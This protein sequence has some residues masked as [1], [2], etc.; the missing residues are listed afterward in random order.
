[1]HGY[2]PGTLLLYLI[3]PN[4]WEIFGWQVYDWAS[5]PYH[6]ATGLILPNLVKE[7]AKRAYAPAANYMGGC[8]AP[9]TA[10]SCPYTSLPPCPHPHPH[11]PLVLYV[12]VGLVVL[13]RTASRV[14]DVMY[15]VFLVL[16]LQLLAASP[17]AR[18][19]FFAMVAFVIIYGVYL[20]SVGLARCAVQ[21]ST[22]MLTPSLSRTATHGF[23]PDPTLTASPTAT[24]PPTESPILYPPEIFLEYQ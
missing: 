20:I 2:L 21:T 8:P 9:N 12:V 23:L 10:M 6:F 7:L 17:D 4:G 13:G 3:T 24:P 18:C 5:S 22:T 14:A 16:G 1:M 11:L 19:R 15:D